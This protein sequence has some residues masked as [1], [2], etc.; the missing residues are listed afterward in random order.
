[1]SRLLLCAAGLLLMAAPAAAHVGAVPAKA[2][3]SAPLGP[4]TTDSAAGDHYDVA[5][6]TFPTADKT[7]TV[8]W[9][10]GDIDPTGRFTFYWLD[11]EPAFQVPPEAI[12][13]IGTAIPNAVGVWV[14]CT[15]ANNADG[16]IICPDAGSRAGSCFNSFVWDTS[17]LPAGSYWI[18]AVNNDPPFHVYNVADAP[19][20][21]AH[22]GAAPP[23]AVIVLRPDGLMSFDQ[24]YRAQWLAVGAAPLRYDLEYGLDDL[25]LSLNPTVP[26]ASAAATTANAD[27]TVSYNWN[28]A[29]LMSGEQYFLR[30]RVT[31]AMGR[32][33]FS[34]SRL[35]L[36]V[37]HRGDAGSDI[38]PVDMRRRIVLPVP[39]DG[40]CRVG[41]GGGAWLP[42][43]ALALALAL[44]LVARRR[45]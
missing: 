1:M 31:D 16:G 36:N 25:D 38:V 23:P 18:T 10:D 27:G 24:Q 12:E 45:T 20:R 39:S 22:G 21:V 15:C 28:L 7:F 5:P 17:A 3:F 13:Q 37:F 6:F 19:V 41:A 29:A 42:V 4:V 8:S 40:G 43:A 26:F 30:V 11:H 35:G 14:S 2:T 33:A 9:D 44:A 34:D 32:V